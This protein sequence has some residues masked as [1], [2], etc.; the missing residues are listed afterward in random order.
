MS[1][2]LGSSIYDTRLMI[3]IA[4]MAR[5]SRPALRKVADFILRYPLS[6]ATLTIDTMAER[7]ASSTAAVNRLA[8]A[9]GLNGYTGLHNA[10]VDNLLGRIAPGEQVRGELLKRPRAGFSLEQQIRL[11][12]GNLDGVAD[13]NGTDTF[14]GLA[15]ALMGASRIH[16]VGLG[17]SY[18]LASVAADSLVEV[19]PNVGTVSTEGGLD[20]ATYRM[21]TVTSADA[22]LTIALPPYVDE[23]MHLVRLARERGAKVLAITDSPASPL[24]EAAD[25]TLFAPAGHAVLQSSRIASLTLIEAL[26]SAIRHADQGA[27]LQQRRTDAVQPA[28]LAPA[29]RGMYAST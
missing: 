4:K 28:S 16:I 26:V 15:R 25:I 6:S 11:T 14:E 21:A 22:L 2:L 24:A 3:H 9:M 1:D 12:K 18:Y 23:T 7:S 5:I 20:M 29:R 13:S 10:L 17:N 19:R 27:L 8:N